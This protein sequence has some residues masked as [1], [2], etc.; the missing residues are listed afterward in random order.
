MNKGSSTTLK[1]IGTKSKPK[2]ASGDKSVATVNT[3]G[4]VTAKKQARP[5][6][7]HELEK[8]NIIAKSL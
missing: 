2:W 5:L 6:L 7:L 8:R 1:I 4:K 3:A